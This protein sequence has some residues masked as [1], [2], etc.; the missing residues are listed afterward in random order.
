[1]NF[2]ASYHIKI[3]SFLRLLSIDLIISHIVAY[4]LHFNSSI[5]IF[6]WYS[7]SFN[8]I[9]VKDVNIFN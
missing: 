9:K 2:R 1:M 7:D 4:I 5:D 3:L 6:I 8:L